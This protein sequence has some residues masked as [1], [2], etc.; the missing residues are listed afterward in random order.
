MSYRFPQ[1]LA[2]SNGDGAAL[3][4]SA[5]ATS[6]LPAHAKGTIGAGQF[7]PQ[8]SSMLRIRATG[9]VSTAASGNPTLTLDV[10]FN[11][12]PII[13]WTGGAITV[14][15]SLTNS[16]WELDTL[17]TVRAFGSGTS[18]NLLGVGICSGI[19][20]ATG[21]VMCPATAPAVGT[22]FDS[23]IS[24]IVDLFGTWSSAVAGTSIT[25]HQY[26]CE[27]LD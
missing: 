12:T 22:G 23:T 3:A 15:V 14:A 25:V 21:Q 27:I 7:S 2:S 18:A 1:I 5:V 17:L 9:R 11:S 4:N 8:G 10:R 13:V 6:L 26:V 16:T 20:S 24:N 19:N